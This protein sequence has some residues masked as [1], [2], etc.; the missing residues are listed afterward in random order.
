MLFYGFVTNSGNLLTWRHTLET[1][2]CN[3]FM[4]INND[5]SQDIDVPPEGFEYLSRVGDLMAYD[6]N[7]FKIIIKNLPHDYDLSKLNKVIINKI[8]EYPE[9]KIIS[10]GC[11]GTGMEICIKIWD[12][13][14]GSLI[15][16]L[17]KHKGCI[18]V[19][20]FLPIV[21]K[22]FVLVSRTV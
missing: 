22:L 3:N 6:K 14:T 1:I 20:V 5:I 18:N 11:D 16:T 19:L 13:S 17:C 12:P 15:K 21:K 2:I 10:R 8:M 7:I 4:G 9:Y